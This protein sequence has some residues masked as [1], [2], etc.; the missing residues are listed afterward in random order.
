M[1]SLSKALPATLI[2]ALSTIPPK[3]KI[4]ISVVP[5]PYQL[6]YYLMA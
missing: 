1:I 5:P 3:D 6:P 4:A 2:E